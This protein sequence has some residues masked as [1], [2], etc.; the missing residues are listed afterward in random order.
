M[1]LRDSNGVYIIA[2]CLL[3]PDEGWYI[4]PLWY[5]CVG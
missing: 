3:L 1:G 2:G 4:V 5:Q